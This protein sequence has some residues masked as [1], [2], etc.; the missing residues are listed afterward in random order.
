MQIYNSVDLDRFRSWASR[1]QE[2]SLRSY[3]LVTARY[4]QDGSLVTQVDEEVEDFLTTEIATHYPEHNVIGEERGS[5]DYSPNWHNIESGLWIIDPIDGT[6]V[7]Y[8]RLPTYA[9]SIALYHGEQCHYAAIN[10]PG[11][12]QKFEFWQGKLLLDHKPLVQVDEFHSNIMASSH[13]AK[14]FSIHESIKVCALGSICFHGCS[15][16]QG[17]CQAVLINQASIWDLAALW[18]MLQSGGFVMIRKDGTS[19]KIPLNPLQTRIDE[20]FVI[21]HENLQ[22][23]ILANV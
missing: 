20:P 8:S 21:T 17:Q 3:G 22:N 23:F 1:I 15:L 13:Y 9:N 11:T 2:I 10:L 18:P 4:K 5:R 12:D 14:H 19:F 16:L 7:Y 6:E